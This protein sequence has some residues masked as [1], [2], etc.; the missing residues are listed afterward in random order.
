M[1]ELLDMAGGVAA[2]DNARS[3]FWRL[4][5]EEGQTAAREGGKRWD[6]RALTAF[7]DD[8]KNSAVAKVLYERD[9]AE[10][11]DM[12][13]VFDAL[14]GSGAG[15]RSASINARTEGVQPSG[16]GYDSALSTS[17]IASRV[18]SVNR[19][20]L[21]PTIALIDIASTYLRRRSAQRQAG[22]IERLQGEIVSSP[23]LAAHLLERYNPADY[24]AK[25]R[26]IAQRHGV[27]ATQVLKLLDDAH[28]EERDPVKGATVRESPLQMNVKYPILTI[29]F[30]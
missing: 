8:P 15:R 30:T 5:R 11:D 16:R 4:R 17:S 23:S 12:R 28:D 2:V 20:Q 13:R 26:M 27:R 25:R 18:R 6:G 19:G 1:R 22:A 14:A 21:S 7:L 29:G 10:L 3:S 24:A 9:P